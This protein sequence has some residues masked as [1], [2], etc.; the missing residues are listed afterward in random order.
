VRIPWTD[1]AE[2]LTD[3]VPGDPADVGQEP[4]R[5]PRPT[6]RERRVDLRVG[7]LLALLTVGSAVLGR[8]VGLF[9]GLPRAGVPESIAWSLAISLPLA[10]RRRY[11]LTSALLVSAAFIGLLARM[12]PELQLS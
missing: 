11:P 3:A 4:W 8:N 5:R 10:V 9:S 6:R 12:V 2:G 1:L 7:V